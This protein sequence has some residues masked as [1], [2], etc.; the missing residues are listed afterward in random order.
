[1]LR[2]GRPSQIKHEE[3]DMGSFKTIRARYTL[4]LVLFMSVIFILTEEGI[5]HFI[6]PRL[7]ASEEQRVLSQVNKIAETIL[8]ELAKV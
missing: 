1:V 4:I 7:K 3:V 8:F 6:T 5:R 2:L